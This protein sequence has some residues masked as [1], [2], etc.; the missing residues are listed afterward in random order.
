MFISVVI[1]VLLFE[2]LGYV[3]ISTLLMIFLV[4]FIGKE[5]W[6]RSLAVT[7]LMVILS[8]FVFSILLKIQLPIGPFGF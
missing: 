7:G 5:R 3:I 4:K 1:A 8:Y 6:A 2:T